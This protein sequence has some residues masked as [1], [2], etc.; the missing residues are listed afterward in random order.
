MNGNNTLGEN[1]ADN[2]G[3]RQAF[4]AYQSFLT[5]NGPEPRLPGLDY[6]PEQLFFIAFSQVN[7][8]YRIFNLERSLPDCFLLLGFRFGVARIQS[9]EWKVKSKLV[10]TVPT[11]FVSE[12]PFITPLNFQKCGTAP[13]QRTNQRVEY[14]R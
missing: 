14:G 2:G 6:S 7:F 4:R 10:F 8:H 1:I 13:N 12:G 11:D 9:R 3:I 5:K